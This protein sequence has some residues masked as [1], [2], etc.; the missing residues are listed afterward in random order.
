MEQE[1]ITLFTLE[2]GVLLKKNNS[3]YADYSQVYDKKH[4]FFN[5]NTIIFLSSGEAAEYALA[6]VMKGVNRTYAVGKELTIP[7]EWLDDTAIDDIKC[8]GIFDGWDEVLEDDLYDCKHI[9]FDMYKSGEKTIKYD[10]IEKEK[11]SCIFK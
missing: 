11:P 6:Y 5:E 4:A 2:V 10:F 7:K 8:G 9:I 1:T 3:E